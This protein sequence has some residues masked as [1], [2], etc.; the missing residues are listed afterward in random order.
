MQV[1]WNF[2]RFDYAR[3]LMLRPLLRAATL[4]EAFAA[5]G[6]GAEIEAIAEAVAEQSLTLEA[7][8][9]ALAFA[10]CCEGDAL[11]VDASFPR[12][13]AAVS[14]RR[15]MEDVGEMLGGL[16]SGGKPVEAWMAADD[17][18]A[19]MLTPDETTRLY[20]ACR[21]LLTGRGRSLSQVG[22]KRGRRTRRGGLVGACIH[23]VRHLLNLG[24][25]PDDLLLLLGT[26]LKA[27]QANE[28]GIAV[29]IA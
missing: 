10:L 8:R 24:P 7:A 23:F 29:T 12:F 4:P 9:N 6:E 5:F 17:G 19:G 26:L 21:P 13:V 20:A 28:Q 2:Y 14:R 22:G 15:G 27:A 16:I 18:I 25:L 11:P 1:S 3:F